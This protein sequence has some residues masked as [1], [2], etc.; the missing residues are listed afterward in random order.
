MNIQIRQ[1]DF[2]VYLVLY[3]LTFQISK[4]LFMLKDGPDWLRA[5]TGIQIQY[6]K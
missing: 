1:C 5:Y 4:K 3:V 2:I 6:V